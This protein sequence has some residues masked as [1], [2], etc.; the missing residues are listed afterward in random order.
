[1]RKFKKHGYFEQLNM[2]LYMNIHNETNYDDDHTQPRDG[3]PYFR[4]HLTCWTKID[5]QK[6]FRRFR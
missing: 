2:Y 5:Y 6:W 1:M 3:R 4:N